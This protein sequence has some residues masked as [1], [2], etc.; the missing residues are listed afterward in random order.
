MSSSLG[1]IIQKIY[2]SFSN[3]KLPSSFNKNSYIAALILAEIYDNYKNNKNR[4]VSNELRF[5]TTIENPIYHLI[6]IL[7]KTSV[8]NG[9]TVENAIIDE[10]KSVRKSKKIKIT[11]FD[12]IE[13][14]LY[15]NLSNTNHLQNNEAMAD[16]IIDKLNEFR[17]HGLLDDDT[18]N[19]LFQPTI[20]NDLTNIIS[21]VQD[22]N[23]LESTL[24][25]YYKILDTRKRNE[26]ETIKIGLASVM[27]EEIN[28][29]HKHIDYVGRTTF[30]IIVGDEES[31]SMTPHVRSKI[32]REN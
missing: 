22:G 2:N 26:I 6:S 17:I 11:L 19:A 12:V 15:E 10:I 20:K 27:E 23:D 28:E 31:G 5:F 30:D 25:E 21:H 4:Y 24:V 8:E 7:E 3:G 32:S 29:L 9:Y 1:V 18:K 13:E 16:Y 14:K